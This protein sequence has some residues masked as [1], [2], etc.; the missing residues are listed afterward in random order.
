MIVINTRQLI[1]E[2]ETAFATPP[3]RT[4]FQ[5][6]RHIVFKHLDDESFG[7]HELSTALCLSP[8]QVYRKIHE[9]TGHSPSVFIRRIR[10]RY[11]YALLVETDLSITQI[12]YRVGFRDLTYFSRCFK[13]RFGRP[14]REVRQ[15]A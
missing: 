8:S 3:P 9:Q 5:C 12:A 4:F 6:A 1:N 14:A 15:D 7:V 10:L 13:R 2:L 11:A